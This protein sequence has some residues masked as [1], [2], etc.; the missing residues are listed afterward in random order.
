MPLAVSM[1]VATPMRT[2]IPLISQ[3]PSKP[4][5]ISN[6]G[7]VGAGASACMRMGR[8][9]CR[10]VHAR[11]WGATVAAMHM[12]AHGVPPLPR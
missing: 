6:G 1:P 11:S 4:S 8:R 5:V 9:H 3:R 12:H 7:S 2:R 10:D